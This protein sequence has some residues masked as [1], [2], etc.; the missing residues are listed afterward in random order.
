MRKPR[1][2]TMHPACPRQ[3]GAAVALTA[4]LLALAGG[5]ANA[6]DRPY[7]IAR[8]AVMEDDEQVWSFES[9]VERRGP[10]RGLSIEPE[11]TFD[12]GT[13]AQM[14]LSRYVDAGGGQT[15]HEAEIEFKQVFNHI[16]R[17]GWALGLSAAFGV[18]RTGE[19]GVV[20]TAGLK[21]PLSIAL[22]DGGGFLHL[23]AGIAKASAASR[24]W[25]SA[26]A[27]ERELL[28]RTSFFAELAHEGELRLAQV[29]ARHWI[30]RE[31]LAIDLAWQQH[32]AGD[33]RDRGFVLG[34]G[35]YDL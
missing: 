19:S 26:I 17:D 28:R 16:G 18:E 29:G 34:L 23:N 7:Q 15:G 27:I 4:V 1:T 32:A 8:T 22:G 20:R 25:T 12:P 30:R 3:P 14:Q 35:W 11:Y 5:A 9:W 21:L 2:S 33:R 13:S 6:N 10:V 31:K 24:V